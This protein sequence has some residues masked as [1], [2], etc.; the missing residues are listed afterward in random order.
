MNPPKGDTPPP[1]PD[2]EACHSLTCAT[3]QQ[4]DTSY[5]PATHTESGLAHCFGLQAYQT[6]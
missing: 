5:I 2:P 1:L 3:E 6:C 4:T